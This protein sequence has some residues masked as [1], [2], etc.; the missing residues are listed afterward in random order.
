MKYAPTI[1]AVALI[2]STAQARPVAFPGAW[3]PMVEVTSQGV[4]AEAMYS[5]NARYSVGWREEYMNDEDAWL[6]TATLNGLVWRE[7]MPKS[8]ANLYVRAALGAATA[9]G[10]TD[11]A[12]SVGMVADWEDRDYM[13][14][15]ENR[16]VMSG[17]AVMDNHFEQRARLGIT[18][19]RTAY[20]DW[21]PWLIMQADHRPES[22]DGA[23]EFT[24][25]LRVFNG[26]PLLAEFC[27]SNK[28]NIFS[29]AIITF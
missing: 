11:L 15:Y 9:P 25:I 6:H 23:W 7:N 22:A 16:Y 19:Y 10:D 4:M 27:V 28:G 26:G 17:L 5:P 3:M 2:A 14:V 21:Q 18:P 12:G 24:P 29:S 20:E 1:L 13:A 8:Q